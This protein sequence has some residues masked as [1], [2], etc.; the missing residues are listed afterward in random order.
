MGGYTGPFV[1]NGDQFALQFELWRQE[2]ERAAR[3]VTA[4]REAVR[5]E[6]EDSGEIEAFIESKIDERLKKDVV[7]NG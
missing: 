4:E 3:A 2:D 6:L 7:N 5:R 1:P